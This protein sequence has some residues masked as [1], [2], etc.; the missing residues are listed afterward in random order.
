MGSNNLFFQLKIIQ[1]NGSSAVIV[2]VVRVWIVTAR[3]NAIAYVIAKVVEVKFGRVRGIVVI[4]VVSCQ[5]T[6][7]VVVGLV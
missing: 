6:S 3:Y 4:V 2:V 7:L 1:V 5:T